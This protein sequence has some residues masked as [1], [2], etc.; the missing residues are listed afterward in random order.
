[1]LGRQLAG[2]SIRELVPASRSGWWSRARIAISLRALMSDIPRFLRY[3]YGLPTIGCTFAKHTPTVSKPPRRAPE[4]RSR[5]SARRRTGGTSPS[6]VCRVAIWPSAQHRY[7]GGECRSWTGVRLIRS[8]FPWE[9]EQRLVLQDAVLPQ[10]SHVSS[11]KMFSE[12]TFGP[13]TLPA[14]NPPVGLLDNRPN[15]SSGFLL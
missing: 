9:E 15:T 14:R 12:G 5:S 4:R 1:M 8:E 6:C 3:R 13:P 10:L 11:V 2:D 7:A